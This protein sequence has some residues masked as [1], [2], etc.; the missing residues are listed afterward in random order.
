MNQIASCCVLRQTKDHLILCKGHA[1]FRTSLTIRN[2][3]GNVGTF[4]M[5]PQLQTCNLQIRKVLLNRPILSSSKIRRLRR[6]FGLTINQSSFG[7]QTVLILVTHFDRRRVH[8][9][10]LSQWL[11]NFSL[12]SHIRVLASNIVLSKCIIA[13]SMFI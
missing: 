3:C 9:Y 8:W 6:E 11:I 5:W 12:I 7:P 4:Q 1:A 13:I 10:T 2:S